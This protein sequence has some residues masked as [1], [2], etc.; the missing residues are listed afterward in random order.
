[1]GD[2]F[3]VATFGAEHAVQA[4]LEPIIDIGGTEA[5][6]LGT[7][8]ALNEE[9]K[10]RLTQLLKQSKDVHHKSFVVP[11]IRRRYDRLSILVK[12]AFD[13]QCP[14]HHSDRDEKSLIREI[15]ADTNTTIRS[16]S[17]L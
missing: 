2:G 11:R 1:M 5:G 10:L 4:C 8:G 15:L 17:R 7:S 14:E 9:R 6:D 13:V 12:G 3:G 16:V